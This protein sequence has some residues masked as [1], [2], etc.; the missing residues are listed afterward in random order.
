MVCMVEKS[1]FHKY[2]SIVILMTITVILIPPS[3]V[4]WLKKQIKELEIPLWTV[5]RN[6]LAFEVSGVIQSV[7][8]T[9]CV[10]TPLPLN[11]QPPPIRMLM[12]VFD[13]GIGRERT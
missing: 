9:N 2:V 11:N 1:L 10:F 5:S 3:G 13:K 7:K 12:L 8:D 6:Q 4:V